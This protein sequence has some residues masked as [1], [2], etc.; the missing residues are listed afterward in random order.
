MTDF[1]AYTFYVNRPDLLRRAVEAFPALWPELTVVDNSGYGIDTELPDSVSVFRPPVPLLYSQ[2][3]NWM[4]A[5]AQ[6]KKVDVI[7]HFHSDA[8]STNPTA[9][10]ELL[11]YARRDLATGLPR[12]CWWTYYDILWAINVKAL[13]DIGGCDTHFRDY[14]T[15]QDLKRRWHLADWETHN[16]HIQGISHEGS[17]TINSDTKLREINARLFTLYGAI[18]CAKW[19]GGAGE[20]VFIHPF[21]NP[22]LDLRP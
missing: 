22:E 19:G 20:E 10:Q 17:A 13:A 18:Y 8:D 16:T 2:S 12:A 7:A 15:D 5:D 9:A 14:F 3:M 4:L 1:A 21:N 11:D 6:R